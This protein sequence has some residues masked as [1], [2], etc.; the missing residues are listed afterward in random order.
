MPEKPPPPSGGTAK[1]GG[2][3][4]EQQAAGTVV[5]PPGP[6]PG[7]TRPPG[8]RR[9]L[10]DA[11][12]VRRLIVPESAPP[13]D[14]EPPVAGRGPGRAAGRPGTASGPDTG[15]RQDPA[16]GRDAGGAPDTA[17]RPDAAGNRA[18]DRWPGQFAQVL[19]ETLAGS[20]PQRQ[21]TPWT[22]EQARRRI[23]QLGPLLAAGQQPR[24][25]RVIA[26]S[27]AADVIEMTVIV[28]FGPRVRFLALRLERDGPQ[29]P[30]RQYG[31]QQ[32]QAGPSR[33]L[34][35]VVEAA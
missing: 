17:G 18:D 13:F 3:D 4:S 27:P 12:A 9:P 22:T 35:T 25:R 11:V 21:I 2:T 14:D 5:L 1:Q 10:P 26:S 23:R 28:R 6:G 32:P 31:P 15:G 29:R 7:A 19:A 34:C 24:L 8:I 20:R 30:G 33:W 16:L